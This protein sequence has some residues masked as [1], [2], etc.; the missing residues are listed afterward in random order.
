MS[1]RTGGMA[2]CYDAIEA[3]R[4]LR[5]GQGLVEAEEENV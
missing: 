5:S 3:I 2:F 4:G 1:A